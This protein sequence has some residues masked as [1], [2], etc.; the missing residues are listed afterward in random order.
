MYRSGYPQL[1]A[2]SSVSSWAH[3]STRSTTPKAADDM[4]VDNARG[5]HPRIDNDR[6]DKFDPRFFSAAEMSSES[7]VLAGRSLMLCRVFQ[8]GA[9][10]AM[11]HTKVEKSSP[12]SAIAR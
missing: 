11:A 10:P 7:G 1:P 4:I 12:A 2:S 8:I 3:V 9:P 6:A 5:L